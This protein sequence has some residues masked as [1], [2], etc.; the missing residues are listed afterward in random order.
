M[1]LFASCLCSLP[2]V[3]SH[4]AGFWG[5]GPPDPGANLRDMGIVAVMGSSVRL[6]DSSGGLAGKWLSF[7]SSLRQALRE[8]LGGA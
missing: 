7:C 4:G 1:V 6:C 2:A 3:S 8:E 5:Y